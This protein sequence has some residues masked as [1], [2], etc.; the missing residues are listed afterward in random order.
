[1][2]PHHNS[3]LP[4]VSSGKL[5]EEAGC[6]EAPFIVCTGLGR[7]MC[8][9]CVQTCPSS[10]A[11]GK[12]QGKR[13]PSLLAAA[14]L[15]S[16]PQQLRLPCR[17]G[18]QLCS[19]PGWLWG[20]KTK[21]LSPPGGSFW[22]GCRAPEGSSPQHTRLGGVNPR[23]EEDPTPPVPARVPPKNG[24]GGQRLVPSPFP[25]FPV[26]G[27]PS[28][29]SSRRRPRALLGA[30]RGRSQAEGA[31]PL[32]PSFPFPFSLSPFLLPFPALLPGL[33]SSMAATVF[34]HW[35]IRVVK[36]EAVGDL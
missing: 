30:G 27:R 31:A 4:Q 21:G 8:S 2:N 14:L 15:S 28:P 9:N 23:W 34:L 7:G 20:D 32:F 12:R 13:A 11:G 25:F 19:K 24:W 3:P 1:M 36:L 6:R 35:A 10:P 18:E 29:V 26:P 5:L 33:T 17:E 22:G 16:S